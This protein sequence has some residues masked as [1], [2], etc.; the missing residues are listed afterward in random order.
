MVVREGF[1]HLKRVLKGDAI[2][3]ATQP[4]LKFPGVIGAIDF[5][6]KSIFVCIARIHET[7]ESEILAVDKIVGD[8]LFYHGL[9]GC[10]EKIVATLY[11]TVRRMEEGAGVRLKQ[12][13]V[14]VGP[15]YMIDRSS[16]PGWYTVDDLRHNWDPYFDDVV[17]LIYGYDVP[18]EVATVNAIKAHVMERLK[19]LGEIGIN[20]CCL[21]RRSLATCL[22]VLESNRCQSPVTLI[23]KREGSAEVA[24]FRE[25]RIGSEFIVPVNIW[26][27][28]DWVDGKSVAAIYPVPNDTWRGANW[29]NGKPLA[30]LYM[31]PEWV[32]QAGVDADG[33][34]DS[35]IEERT[36]VTGTVDDQT[37]ALYDVRTELARIFELIQ[38][39]SSADCQS[40]E[41]VVTGAFPDSP[42]MLSF[43]ETISPLPVR[44][45]IPINIPG[46]PHEFRTP[47][48]ATLIGLVT[49]CG[50]MSRH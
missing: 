3:P 2:R 12:A 9:P 45:G 17:S 15:S 40:E 27:M 23:D 5:R 38:Q 47:Q 26:H 7:G 33:T 37:M 16:T 43:L 28:P 49:W 50:N 8:G 29:L 36:R 10:H 22:G 44:M 25:E 11:D 19:I 41:I 18:R 21:V 24:A 14:S 1:Q 48:Y 31:G 35:S 4:V 6:S 13:C 32:A 46:L 30:S 39:K 20:R 34:H 42:E